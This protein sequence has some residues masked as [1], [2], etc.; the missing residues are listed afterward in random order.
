MARGLKYVILTGIVIVIVVLV[1]G[2]A[3][4]AF[5]FSIGTSVV[6]VRVDVLVRDARTNAPVSGCL[7]AFE[8]SETGGFGRTQERS[9]PDGRATHETSHSSVGSVLWPFPRRQNVKL[10]FYLGP[11]PFYGTYEETE[12]WDV[13]LEFRDPSKPGGDAKPTVTLTRGLA[14]EEVLNP[15]PGKQWQQAGT[16]PLPAGPAGALQAPTVRLG[17]EGDRETYLVPITV[18]LDEAQIAS[19]RRAQE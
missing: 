8:K 14:H 1:A 2:V 5:V 9:G 19:C 7:L 6:T 13:L 11:P 15:P 3:T 17:R 18:V 4:M 10:R 12:V 16:K